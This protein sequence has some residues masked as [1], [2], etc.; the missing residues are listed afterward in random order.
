[1]RKSYV[2]GAA[3][4]FAPILAL[5]GCGAYG[6]PYGGPGGMMGGG[7]GFG[8]GGM[9][10]NGGMMGGWGGYGSNYSVPGR[11]M[12]TMD[13]VAD[14]V[15][16][17]LS[18]S[19]G[20]LQIA[21]VM[22]FSQNYYAEVEE[23]DTGIHAMELLIDKYTGAISPE[24]GP[25]TMW[26]TKYS[27]MG[28]MMGAYGAGPNTSNMPVIAQRAKELAQ[29]YLDSTTPGLSVEEPDVFYGYYTLHTTRNGNVEGMLSVNGYNGAVWDHTWHGTFLGMKEFS[30]RPA[31]IGQKSR[32]IRDQMEPVLL[33][34]PEF[35][36]SPFPRQT[37]NSN[38]ILSLV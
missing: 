15:N 32:S 30:N 1:M 7:A 22:E 8:G 10:G 19:K 31:R 5:A 4:V 20:N 28:G 26:N 33:Q 35:R 12:L 16:R 11:Q 37:R 6:S 9:M 34:S 17:Y 21:E 27:M 2:I 36:A 23:R 29:Q 38:P 14:S 3:L 13:Q 24:M 25:S 18:S